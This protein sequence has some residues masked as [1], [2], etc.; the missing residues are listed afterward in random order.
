VA[1]VA[2]AAPN[3]MSATTSRLG[4]GTVP[5]WDTA[6][7]PAEPA[8][9]VTESDREELVT[10]IAA[11]ASYLG[12]DKPDSFRRARTRHPVPGRTVVTVPSDQSIVMQTSDTGRRTGTETGGGSSL[13]SPASPAR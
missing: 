11:A 9:Q 2:V 5:P 4:A 12:Y 6:A 1:A 3:R 7:A 8:E 13:T 10:G